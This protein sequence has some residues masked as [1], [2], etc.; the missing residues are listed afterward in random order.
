MKIWITYK[1]RTANGA[2]RQEMVAAASLS[3]AEEIC[4][5]I[6]RIGYKLIDVS[7]DVYE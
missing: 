6:D 4:N 7:R 2:W 3:E 1:L 5:K